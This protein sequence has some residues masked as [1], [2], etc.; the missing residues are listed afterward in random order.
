MTRKAVVIALA[1]VAV[2]AGAYAAR[3]LQTLW[4]PTVVVPA[5]RAISIYGNVDILSL[6]KY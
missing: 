1:L 5:E 2:L 3:K 6:Y 4:K